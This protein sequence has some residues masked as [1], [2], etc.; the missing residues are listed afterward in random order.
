MKHSDK[1]PGKTLA[2]SL[3][4][5]VPADAPGGQAIPVIVNEGA[6]R[7]SR[8]R[9]SANEA[10]YSGFGDYDAWNHPGGA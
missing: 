3:G 6:Q 2:E 10:G 9:Q 5:Q 4:I 7:S 8:A 1:L